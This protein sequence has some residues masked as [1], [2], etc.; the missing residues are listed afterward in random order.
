MTVE[1]RIR[2]LREDHDL[3]QREVA[4]QLYIQ[5]KTYSR[6]ELGH[7]KLRTDYL[8]IL[9]Q[10]YKVTADDILGLID[11]PRPLKK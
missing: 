7:L 5:Q 11:E 6:Y 2:S 9:C 8:I 3:K 1:E 4:A 10:Y